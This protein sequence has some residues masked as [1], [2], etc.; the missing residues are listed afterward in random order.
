MTKRRR[1]PQQDHSSAKEGDRSS[2]AAETR[3]AAA[4]RWKLGH[5]QF[6]LNL[7]RHGLREFPEDSL[8]WM[9]FAQRLQDSGRYDLAYFGFTNAVEI[10]PGNFAALE[11][12]IEMAGDREDSTAVTSVLT[13]LARAIK[14]KPNRHRRALDFAIPNKITE[15]VD[16]VAATSTDTV[17][18]AAAEL[19][20]TGGNRTLMGVS[21]PESEQAWVIFCLARGRRSAAITGM[22]ALTSEQIPVDSLRL[23]IRRD[24]RRE[25][26]KGAEKL[27]R[28]YL[29]HKPDDAWAKKKLRSFTVLND[30]QLT[31]K[32]FP[33]PKKASAPVYTPNRGKV[34]Y[35][36]HNSLPYNSAGYATRTHGLLSALRR[37]EWD[38]E[39]VTRLGYPFDMTKHD[40]LKEIP[41]EDIIDGVPYRRLSTDAELQLKKPIQ[42]YTQRYV[43]R[44]IEFA[45]ENR[46][47]II[48]A[49]SNHWN[50]LAA[51]SAANKLGLPSI[52]E[53]RGLWEVTRGSRDPKWAEGGMFRYMAK[54]ESEAAANA[55]RVIAITQALKDE[56]MNRGVDG[57]KIEVVPNGVDTKRFVPIERNH[58]LA[59]ALGIEGK[60]VIGYI[61]SILDYEGLGLLIEAA[62]RMA[63]VRDDFVVML[64]GDGAE[65]E[66]FTAEVEE[67][68]FAHLFRIT[69]RVPHHEVE[70]YYSLVDI[71]PFPRLPLPVCEMVSPLKP[72]EAMAMGKAVVSSDVA[73]LAEI[74][75]P[76][77]N[78]FRHIKGDV[79]SLQHE[80]ERLLD[81]PELVTRLGA[82][83]R[84]WV[85]EERDWDNLA[86]RIDRLYRSLDE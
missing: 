23:A 79:V 80:L 14:D 74:V 85:A 38:I 68:G 28:E 41:S 73:A 1:K 50:G 15:V 26:S 22:T 58:E 37:L 59:R 60:T 7:Y 3:A 52:Y 77:L 4:E 72:F 12:F 10:D 16:V 69:G 53:V 43:N 30:Y 31:V 6:A 71:A 18:K 35:L 9:S 29:R 62:I 84:T 61:G 49:A 17:A 48:H 42:L 25:N 64:V 24:L 70:Q 56:L 47:S 19:E 5:R 51:V 39:G 75:T 44:F 54:M 11:Q 65:L 27:L 34:S 33:F 81:D 78:G 86:G 2:R 82:Q 8:L 55:T 66:R 57:D 13:G 67:S 32:G 40:N 20:R 46:P 76:G 83:A 36:L 63:V 45:H 21:G